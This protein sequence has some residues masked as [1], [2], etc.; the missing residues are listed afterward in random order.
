MFENNDEVRGHI[1]MLL[2]DHPAGTTADLLDYT[3][4]Y[5]NGHEVMGLHLGAD[6]PGQIDEDFKLTNEFLD[7]I[8]EAVEGWL[9]HP[10][11]TLRPELLKRLKD[12]PSF[13]LVG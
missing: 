12:M 6:K 8:P 10:T 2:R 1:R 4:A 13:K 11:Y 3:V 9:S 7:Q 5:F